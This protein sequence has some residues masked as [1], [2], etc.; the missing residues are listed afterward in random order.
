VGLATA[1]S[2]CV[3]PFLI[4]EAVKTVLAFIVVKAVPKRV[5]AF[6]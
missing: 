4:P 3:L 2:W 5:K 1:L 6:R